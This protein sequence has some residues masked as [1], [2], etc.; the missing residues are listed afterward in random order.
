MQCIIVLY[1]CYIEVYLQRLDKCHIT[2]D[3]LKYSDLFTLIA[4]VCFVMYYLIY[5]NVGTKYL[6]IYLYL[7]IYIIEFRF[8]WLFMIYVII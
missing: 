6:I 7:L 2:V 3:I 8:L 5:S 1:Y 4:D